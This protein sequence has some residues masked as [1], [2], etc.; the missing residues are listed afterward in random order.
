MEKIKWTEELIKSLST[1]DYLKYR[2]EIRSFY[3][4]ILRIEREKR[5]GN[6]SYLMKE[7][8][9]NRLNKSNSFLF[10]INSLF[11]NKTKRKSSSYL[12]APWMLYKKNAMARCINPKEPKY[13]YYGGKGIKYLL[14]NDDLKFMWVRDKAWKLD[15]PP[16]DRKNSNGDYIF[17]N[18][19]FI[20][21]AKNR[22]KN[23]FKYK[24]N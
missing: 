17:I 5:G 14:S 10:K 18:C 9:L 8:I 15:Q 7:E 6:V 3:K 13:K 11:W 23:N 12:N 21:F 1:K 22:I 19:Q 20:E 4:E 24:K 16:I 2:E